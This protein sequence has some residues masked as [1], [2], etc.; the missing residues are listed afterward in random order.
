MLAIKKSIG[1]IVFRLSNRIKHFEI[2]RIQERLFKLKSEQVTRFKNLEKEFQNKYL[3]Y[4]KYD[5][6]K[7]M[8]PTWEDF[9]KKIEIDLLP[10]PPIDFF[11]NT[12]VRETMVFSPSPRK[13]P[14]IELKYLK[15]HMSSIGELKRILE[16]DYIGLPDLPSLKYKTS[17]NSIHHLYH[18]L[19]FLDETHLDLSLLNT[20]V[21]WGGGYGNMAKLFYRLKPSS[22]TY[23]IIDVP[24]FSCLQWLYLSAIMG[25]NQVFLFQNYNDVIQ[26]GK[27]NLIPV[28]FIE[29]TKIKANLFISTWGLSE[30]S[31]YAQDLVISTDFFMANH[32]LLAFQRS[33]QF[34]NA[35]RLG[36]LIQNKDVKIQEIPFLRK[37]F[38][39]FQ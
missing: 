30:S 9:I 1:K 25:E 6:K 32:I 34:P 24:Y 12:I 3:Y 17:D 23:I 16:E 19:R 8:S 38:Y 21:E 28:C 37:N 10:S 29:S 20:I 31:S 11:Q 35:E 33:E 4:K 15:N 27:V 36:K 7:F 5:I 26:E 22:L 14:K 39:A 13:I 18:I 2:K